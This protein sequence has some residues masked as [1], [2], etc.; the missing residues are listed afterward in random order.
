MTF[1]RRPECLLN[2]L[3]K[4]NLRPVS[5]GAIPYLRLGNLKLLLNLEKILQHLLWLHLT[6]KVYFEELSCISYTLWTQNLISMYNNTLTWSSWPLMNGS[7]ALHFSGAP[8][9]FQ[10][11]LNSL[12]VCLFGE[13]AIRFFPQATRGRSQPS[14]LL[15]FL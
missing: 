12:C 13:F 9:K 5:T 8:A 2:V 11:C 6:S 3:C 14:K 4:F 7:C 10:L 15:I 1:R